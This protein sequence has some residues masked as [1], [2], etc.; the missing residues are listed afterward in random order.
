M[1]HL[2]PDLLPGSLIIPAL[3]KS[4][5]ACGRV[6][7]VNTVKRFDGSLGPDVKMDS[8]LYIES[9]VAPILVLA[10]AKKLTDP[11]ISYLL[12][13]GNR[14]VFWL[15]SMRSDLFVSGCDF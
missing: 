10:T 4:G 8:C 7:F 15:H 6:I 3:N 2:L 5:R 14:G 9:F 1:K 11:H 12:V 13:L